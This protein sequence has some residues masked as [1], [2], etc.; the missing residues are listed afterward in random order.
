MDRKEKLIEIIKEYKDTPF[1]HQGR[2]KKIGVD[3]VGLIICACK[4]VGLIIKDCNDYNNVPSKGLL[5]NE[6][7]NQLILKNKENIDVG[8]VLLFKF[9]NDPQHV[10]LVTEINDNNIKIIHS[11]SKV[12]KVIEHDLDNL[13]KKRL[14]NVYEIKG[15]K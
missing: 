15:L 3:C 2:V 4:E 6:L 11:Y 1:H 5:E 10:A 14:I 9:L 7:N 13:W 8:D 12:G